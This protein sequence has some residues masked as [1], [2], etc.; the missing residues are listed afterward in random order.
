MSVQRY[1]I[2]CFPAGIRKEDKDGLWVAYSD[3]AALAAEVER[4]RSASFV[5]AVPSEQYERIIK[6]GDDLANELQNP[7]SSSYHPSVALWL[8]AKEGGSK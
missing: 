6:A 4:L 8:A 2:E 7:Q 3:Y 5:T 1:T